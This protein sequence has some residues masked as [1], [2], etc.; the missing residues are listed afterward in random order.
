MSV[1]KSGFVNTHT[2]ATVK[3]L[4][5]PP[6]FPCGFI[7]AV[8]VTKGLWGLK[9]PENIIRHAEKSQNIDL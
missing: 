8:R 2:K 5:T 6:R 3:G 9:P 4:V 1:E 7:E